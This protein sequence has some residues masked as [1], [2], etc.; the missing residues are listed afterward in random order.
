M[1]NFKPK[2]LGYIFDVLVKVLK[3]EKEHPQG[4]ELEDYPRLA[5]FAE[6]GEIVSRCMGNEK[7]EVYRTHF[8]EI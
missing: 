1:K 3:Y 2:L 4:L 8:K 7:M 5:D 6:V